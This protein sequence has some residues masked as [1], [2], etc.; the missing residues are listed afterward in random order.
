M[1][2]EKFYLVF[3][4]FSLAFLAVCFMF[5]LAWCLVFG[6]Y[7]TLYSPVFLQPSFSA[8][9]SYLSLYIIAYWLRK[10]FEWMVCGIM[11]EELY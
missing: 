11:R 4:S 8:S 1:G 6:H 3:L 2:W 5:D 7:H 9:I 10:A